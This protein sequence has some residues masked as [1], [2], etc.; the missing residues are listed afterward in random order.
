MQLVKFVVFV[1]VVVGGGWW[2]FETGSHSAVHAGQQLSV[3]LAIFGL[4]SSGCV[5]SHMASE[6][7]CHTDFSGFSRM[8]MVGDEVL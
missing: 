4:Q 1:I 7:L 8:S 6:H 5:S 2:L 3:T